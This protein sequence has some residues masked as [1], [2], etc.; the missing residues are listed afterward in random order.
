M[1]I[2][3]KSTFIFCIFCCTAILAS[4]GSGPIQG[5]RDSLA[6]NLKVG[7]TPQQVVSIIGPSQFSDESPTDPS[8]ICRSYIYDEVIGAKYVHAF[9]EDGKL[10]SASD[11]HLTPCEF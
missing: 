3:T 9:F 1:T 7:M 5:T 2:F 10:V 4:C 6:Y 11:G 8:R